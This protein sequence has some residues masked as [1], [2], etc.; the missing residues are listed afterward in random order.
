MRGL[1]LLLICLLMPLEAEADGIRQCTHPDGSVEWR[2][3]SCPP[4]SDVRESE[5]E[6]ANGR[7]TFNTI[8]ANRP[9][10]DLLERAERFRRRTGARS[11]TSR[12][13]SDASERAA[14]LRCAEYEKQID[15]IDRR[16]RKGYTVSEGN[17][18]RA[19]RRRIE[20]ALSKACR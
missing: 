7:G 5:H 14:E 13:E 3:R 18:L 19:E 1:W 8:P 2:N 11:R 17:E 10:P 9:P 12:P 16:L 20:R 15:A 6:T 4:G